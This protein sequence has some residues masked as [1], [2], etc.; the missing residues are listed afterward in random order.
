MYTPH[1]DRNTLFVIL[2]AA[3]QIINILY[4][5]KGIVKRICPLT[6]SVSILHVLTFYRENITKI[7]KK[8][9]DL[10]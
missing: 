7:K 6:H 3:G 1:K 8:I 4:L 2:L 10:L 5:I 9:M